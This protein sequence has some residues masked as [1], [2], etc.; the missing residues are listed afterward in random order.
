MSN[1]RR[2][3]A[4]GLIAIIGV[5]LA[6]RALMRSLPRGEQRR[7]RAT[8]NTGPT[9]AR[10]I[11]SSLRCEVPIDESSAEQ[12]GDMARTRVD[13]L[14]AN[15]SDNPAF[16]GS[17]REDLGNAFRESLMKTV[18]P[19]LDRDR[20]ALAARGVPVP[21]DPPTDEYR[22]LWKKQTD[23]F[24]L[25]PIGFEQAE[26][27]VLQA[28]GRLLLAPPNATADGFNVSQSYKMGA[29]GKS[30]YNPGNRDIVEVRLPMKLP[31]SDG[32]AVTVLMGYMYAWDN[33]SGDWVPFMNTVYA[34]GDDRVWSTPMPW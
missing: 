16:S 26:V 28:G 31:S 10:A 34:D 30:A 21:K 22:E 15:M 13:E 12:V 11:I 3:M 8:E 14:L 17:R 27:R 4:A 18:A 7:Q 25:A 20:A 24:R 5:F 33:A 9:E 23:P 6:G 29:D 2:W 19:D 1:G 32:P